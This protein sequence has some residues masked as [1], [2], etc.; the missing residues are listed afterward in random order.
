MID[1]IID[2]HAHIYFDP[3]EA[4]EARKFGEA[5]VARFAGLAMGRVHS[6]PIGPHPRGSCQL[7]VPSYL[8]GGVLAWLVLQ[9]GRFTIFMHANTGDDLADHTDHVIWLGPSETL[10]LTDFLPQ[11]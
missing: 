4:D 3:T 2:Y 7:T 5:A 8:V 9:R 10:D 11:P 1:R 6:R